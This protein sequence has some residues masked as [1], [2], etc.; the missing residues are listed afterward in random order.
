MDAENVALGHLISSITEIHRNSRESGSIDGNIDFFD[1]SEEEIK[2]FVA[3]L[4]LDR[5]TTSREGFKDEV[6]KSVSER[7]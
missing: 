7:I 3:A 5:Y 2:D 1:F 6:S 4:W